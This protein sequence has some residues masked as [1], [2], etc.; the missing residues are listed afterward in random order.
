M[1]KEQHGAALRNWSTHRGC[2]ERFLLL[3]LP[4]DTQ[5]LP[6]SI[7]RADVI[8]CAE[9]AAQRYWPIKS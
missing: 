6:S 1:L 4:S 3:A 5:Y 9:K 2:W 7:S 8:S